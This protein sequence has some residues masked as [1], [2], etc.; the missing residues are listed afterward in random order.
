MLNDSVFLSKK[1]KRSI[2]K[3]FWKIHTY[4]EEQEDIFKKLVPE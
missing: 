2:I 4:L 1:A 3:S